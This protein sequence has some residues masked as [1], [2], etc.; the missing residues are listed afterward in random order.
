MKDQFHTPEV[1]VNNFSVEDVVTASSLT[2]TTGSGDE[3]T[4]DSLFGQN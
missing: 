4:Y 1:E 3:G 2:A